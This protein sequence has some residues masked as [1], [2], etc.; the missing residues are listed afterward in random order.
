MKLYNLLEQRRATRYF[1]KTRE[2]EKEKLEAIMN[3]ALLSP[4]GFNLQ[5]WR[6]L[7]LQSEKQKER[8]FE[9]AFKQEKIKEASV[10]LVCC[11]DLDCHREVEKISSDMVKKNYMPPEAEIGFIKMVKNFYK[12]P[13]RARDSI[14]RDVMLASMVIMMAAMEAEVDSAPMSGFD[15]KKLKK[16]FDLPENM[17]PVLLIALGYARKPNP[18]R[19]VRK[20]L[21]EVLFYEKWEK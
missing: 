11:G 6:F 9:C 5:P 20:D 13:E 15:A 2:I 14:F 21:S 7:A 3:H 8:L 16:E 19:G 18:K 12:N 1:D 17:V 10:V 4:S